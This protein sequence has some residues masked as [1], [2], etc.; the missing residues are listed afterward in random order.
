MT[1]LFTFYEVIL[2][3]DLGHGFNRLVWVDFDCFLFFIFFF[4]HWKLG[5]LK[6]EILMFFLLS[7]YQIISISWP[8]SR[9]L[10]VDTT[11]KSI[12]TNGDTEGIFSSV[13]FRGILPTEIFPRYIPR[14]LQ[15][16]KKLKQSKKKWWRVIFTNGFTDGICSVGKLWTLF[17]MLI[18]KGITNGKI[19]SVF[20]RE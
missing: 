10:H 6:I 16:E 3:H 12:N 14:E 18:T 9:V 1:F 15:W 19:P 13:N 2:I 17:I 8:I 5:R 7:F 20:S 4:H 11:R